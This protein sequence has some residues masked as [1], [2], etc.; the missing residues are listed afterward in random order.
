M[1]TRQKY[2]LS[3][4]LQSIYTIGKP[5]VS[6]DKKTLYSACDSDF[7]IIDIDTLKPRH[8]IT[9]DIKPIVSFSIDPNE[10]F[11][12]LA[13]ESNYLRIYD[14]KTQK[15]LHEYKPHRSQICCIEFSKDGRY[16]AS[17]STDS[18]IIVWD[19]SQRQILYSIRD[20][21]TI[22][23]LIFDPIKPVIYFTSMIQKTI[24]VH[25]FVAKKRLFT[26]KEHVSTINDLLISPDGKYLFSIGQDSM[27]HM[28]LLKEN[29]SFELVDS[30]AT[31]ES[32]FFLTPLD[33]Y[34]EESLVMTNE[35]ELWTL[36]SGGEKGKL[37]TVRV[38]P[39][40]L[41]SGI[42]QSVENDDNEAV[43]SKQMW[44]LCVEFP[45]KGEACLLGIRQGLDMEILNMSN[46]EHIAAFP[47]YLEPSYATKFFP[48][49]H[50]FVVSVTNSIYLRMYNVESMETFI[51]K[52]H[53]DVLLNCAVSSRLP[54]I[55]T[56]SHDKTVC[57]WY[58][59]FGD[60]VQIMLLGRGFGHTGDPNCVIFQNE[61]IEYMITGS[62]DKTLKFWDISFVQRLEK[63]M[64]HLSVDE[65]IDFLKNYRNNELKTLHTFIAHSDNVH[66]IDIARKDNF[67]ATGSK[68]RSVK[69]WR[70]DRSQ[71]GEFQP[72]TLLETFNGHRRAVNNVK[73]SRHEKLLGSCSGDG[74]VKIWSLSTMSLFKTLET[75]TK[76][77]TLDFVFIS[78]GQQL[79]SCGSDGLISLFNLKMGDKVQTFAGHQGEKIWQLDSINDGEMVVSS[80]ADC[81]IKFWKDETTLFK[82]EQFQK[83]AEMEK[84]LDIIDTCIRRGDLVKAG[85]LSLKY[86]RPRRLFDIVGK[87]QASDMETMID[88]VKNLDEETNLA[89][90][91]DKS[92]NKEPRKL[93]LQIFTFEDL[94]NV[95]TNNDDMGLLRLLFE[96]IKEWISNSRT[97]KIAN[98]LLQAIF[99]T[100]TLEEIFECIQNSSVLINT[101]L[102]YA[103]K[104]ANRLDNLHVRSILFSFAAK[105]IQI[106]PE[107]SQP[108]I[109]IAEDEYNKAMKHY[110]Q[111]LEEEALKKKK[112]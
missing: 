9:P 51:G 68:D 44:K 10:K 59:L 108:R 94:D 100:L 99:N 20:E 34:K 47:G 50:K 48:F 103:E 110:N 21:G 70:I 111:L 8:V 64:E 14:L 30:Y 65:K 31:F 105:Q 73:F 19:F 106:V 112:N 89:N 98:Q 66:C 104:Y 24:K 46:L 35:D 79:I 75:A 32:C 42:V 26:I 38:L 91:S 39:T 95:E 80:G 12:I 72:P 109:S 76:S 33:T 90:S 53:T 4:Y 6:K 67:I 45:Y 5:I 58:V 36:L 86:E 40:G 3:H 27:L 29:N 92:Q 83:E 63:K 25:D 7:L 82:E 93:H 62:D 60:N 97:N 69:L 56:V 16:F 84:E 2:G 78:L 61:S 22:S 49:D 37:F 96:F 85:L 74:T 28:F 41:E 55:A 18:L 15:L 23:H 17:C 101:L 54:L 77:S 43:D 88:F 107:K 81:V 57:L 87:M 71:I 11:L 1:T 102:A 52:G 13:T